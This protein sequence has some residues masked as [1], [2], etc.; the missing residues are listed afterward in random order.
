ME[1]PTEMGNQNQTA[2]NISY[3]LVCA[4]VRVRVYA[5]KI[6]NAIRIMTECDEFGLSIP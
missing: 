6:S 4:C 2:A 1:K 3:E 5:N